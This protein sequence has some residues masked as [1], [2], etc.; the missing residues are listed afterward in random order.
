MEAVPVLAAVAVKV[1]ELPAQT[2]PA[3]STDIEF[4]AVNNEFTE[5]VMMLET[6]VLLVKQVPP[7]IF[8]SQEILS[9]FARVLE[10]NIFEAL[11]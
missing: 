4:V 6:A 3:G 11:L 8:I 9:P 5:M 1:T 2:G 10:V 7:V